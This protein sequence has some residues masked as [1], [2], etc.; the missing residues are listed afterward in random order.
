MEEFREKAI[1]ALKEAIKG[2]EAYKLKC[3]EHFTDCQRG[4]AGGKIDG[5]NLA[6]E[7]LKGVI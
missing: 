1:A 4:Y 7:I 6:I 3:Q 5:L 2:R